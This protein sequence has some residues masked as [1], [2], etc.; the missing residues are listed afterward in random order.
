LIWTRVF[1]TPT[2]TLLAAADEELIGR[3]LKEGKFKLNVSIN[4][5]KEI[6]VEDSALRDLLSM[7]SVANLVGNRTVGIAI[8]AGYI[9]RD[10]VIYIQGVA[11]AQ[12][13]TME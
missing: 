2:D 11:H 5:Y 10:N 4:F 9:S 3:E 7:C 12:F 1:R 6:L 13:T 8:E